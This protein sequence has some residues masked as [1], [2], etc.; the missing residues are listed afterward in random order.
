MSKVGTSLGEGTVAWRW[1]TTS[2]AQQGMVRPNHRRRLVR[3]VAAQMRGSP[4]PAFLLGRKGPQRRRLLHVTRCLGVIRRSVVRVAHVAASRRRGKAATRVVRC[5]RS[6]PAVLVKGTL[7]WLHRRWRR[8]SGHAAAVLQDAGRLAVVIHRVRVV[9]AER[10]AASRR[11]VQR[12][13]GVVWRS[14]LRG[15]CCTSSS[16]GRETVV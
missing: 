6:G 7:G 16:H 4:S 3:G 11:W 13:V 1:V 10:A 2:S 14:A 15:G 8:R 5:G 12:E 9:A